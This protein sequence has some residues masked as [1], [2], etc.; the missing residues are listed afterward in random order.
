[1]LRFIR[2]LFGN[3]VAAVVHERGD[4][5]K[6]VISPPSRSRKV[7]AT[8]AYFDSMSRRRLFPTETTKVP[9]RSC[10]RTSA[11]SLSG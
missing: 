8:D 3:D 10:A 6:P 2:W 9:R 4:E 11:L 5:V 1:M 7:R